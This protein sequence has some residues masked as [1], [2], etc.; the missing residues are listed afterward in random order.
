MSSTRERLRAEGAGEYITEDG[1]YLISRADN[2]SWYLFDRGVIGGDSIFFG[3]TLRSVR[4]WLV[5]LRR[6]TCAH[7]VPTL[8]GGGLACAKCSGL[9]YC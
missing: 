6:P 4:D 2:G 7:G 9:R 8:S 1:R 3:P 5:R